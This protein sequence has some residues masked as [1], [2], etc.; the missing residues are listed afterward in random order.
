MRTFKPSKYY[1]TYS[2]SHPSAFEVVPG[3]T[4]C[5]E[6][7]D[8]YRGK[9]QSEEDTPTLDRIPFE[10]ANPQSGP[11]YVKGAEKGDTLSVEIVDIVIKAKQ[12]ATTIVPDMGGLTRT[13]ITRLLN[14]PL[15]P[16]AKICPIT[17]GLIH[18]SDTIHIPVEPMIGT[19][20]VAPEFEAISS[21]TPGPHGGNMDCPDVCPGNKVMFPVYVKGAFLFLGDVHA[22]QGDGEISGSAIEV[23]A[24]CVLKVDIVKKRINWPRIESKDYIMTVG[25][26]RPLEDALRIAMVELIEWLV[27]EYNFNKF[28]AYQ[29]C[30]QV[31]KIRVAQMVDPLYTMVAKFPKKYLRK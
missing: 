18:F 11:I 24:E 14:E 25:S 10:N 9:I 1:S 13:N 4:F 17:N 2:A 5:V 23:P 27:D 30:S 6:T 28:D 31:A 20:G 16:R 22:V 29:L 21:L 7:A 12:G 15:P 26:A 8:A 3:E 19:I